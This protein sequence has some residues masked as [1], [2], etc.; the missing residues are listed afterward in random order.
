MVVLDAIS[1]AERMGLP[2]V[3]L[4]Y[5][6][7]GSQKMEYK[8]RFRPQERLTPGGWVLHKSI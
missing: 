5:F 7:S 1:R 8:G 2:Y 4:G 3:Y 6:V